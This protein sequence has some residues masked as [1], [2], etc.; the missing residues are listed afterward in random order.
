MQQVKKDGIGSLARTLKKQIGKETA[1]PL[2]LDFGDIGPQMELTTNS[3]PVPIPPDSYKVCRQLTLG[4]TDSKLTESMKDGVHKLYQEPYPEQPHIRMDGVGEEH[5][6]DIKIPEKMRSL[7]PGD[8]V[9]VAW[10][11][12]DA[13]II[14]IVVEGADAI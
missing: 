6:H 11:G 8:T 7:K 13:V 9:L 3:F 14:D 10:I 12:S 5:K 1:S 4:P 2:I